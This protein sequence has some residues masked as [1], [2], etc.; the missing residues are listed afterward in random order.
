MRALLLS[1]TLSLLDIVDAHPPDHTAQF[2]EMTIPVGK[3]PIRVSVGDVNHDGHSDLVVA[4]AE[5][6]T[7][8]LLLGNGQGQFHEAAGSPFPAGHL[9]NDIAIADMNGDGNSDLVIANH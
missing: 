9:P 6:G 7:V 4:N 5:S 2:K 1:L 8:S 3:G